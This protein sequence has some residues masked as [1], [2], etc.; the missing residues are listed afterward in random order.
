M[1]WDTVRDTPFVSQILTL[2][3]QS[4][5]LHGKEFTGT[6]EVHFLGS[7]CQQEKLRALTIIVLNQSNSNK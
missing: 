2:T 6:G 7:S 5:L 1:R 3:S 4:H